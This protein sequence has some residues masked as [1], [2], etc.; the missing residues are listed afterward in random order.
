MANSWYDLGLQG[1]GDQS[2]AMLTDDIR[3]ALVTAGY[4][5]NL[6]TDQFVSDVGGGNIVARSTA[7]QTKSFTGGVF[8]AANITI[9][10]VSGSVVTQA[11]IYKYNASDS[12]ARLIMSIDTGTGLPLTPNGGDVPVTWSAGATKIGKL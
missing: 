9:V 7:L 1:V 12:L 2:I 6:A 8:N 11:V 3:I 5:R 4:T 10:G